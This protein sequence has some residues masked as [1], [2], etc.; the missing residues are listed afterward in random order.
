MRFFVSLMAGLVLSIPLAQADDAPSALVATQP[1]TSHDMVETLTGY[2]TVSGQPGQVFNLTLPSAGR[3]DNVLVN[4]GQTV[5]K[6]Q[7]L[8]QFSADASGRLAYMQANNALTYA[9]RDLARQQELRSQQL[10]TNAQV[11]A[12]EHAVHDAEQALAAQMV[13]GTDSASM[14]VRAPVAGVVT[15]LTVAPGDRPA[16]GA[17]LGQVTAGNALQVRLGLLPEE[18]RQVRTG[19]KVQVHD[20]FD[21][22]QQAEGTVSAIGGAIDAA[23][24]RTDVI[25]HLD[26]V[27]PPGSQ[28]KGVVTLARRKRLAVPRQAVLRDDGGSY[29]F[30]V[31]GGRA[32]RVNV[33]EGGESNGLIAIS[34]PLTPNAPVV[35]LGNYELIDGMAVREGTP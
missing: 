7:S 14:T 13:L 1:L 25:V 17:S 9:R 31:V 15:A 19:M 16:A 6:G 4:V 24:R 28:V 32:H 12:A 22:G 20:V 33:V 34:G 2:G 26:G 21:P 30:Q 10:A 29:V 23:S 27:L 18:A 35:T 5:R 8:L 11:D 3:V